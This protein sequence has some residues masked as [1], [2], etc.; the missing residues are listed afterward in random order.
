MLDYRRSATSAYE[1]A[2]RC[3]PDDEALLDSLLTAALDDFAAADLGTARAWC[4]YTTRAIA[5]SNHE[6]ALVNYT[7]DEKAALRKAWL[8][9]Y[10]LTPEESRSTV[11]MAMTVAQHLG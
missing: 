3:L 4:A 1:L 6:A 10:G 7:N 9:Q 11:T 2:Y 5:C 8:N